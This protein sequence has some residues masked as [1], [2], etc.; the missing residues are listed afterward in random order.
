MIMEPN[1]LKSLLK[2]LEDALLKL[3]YG[4]KFSLLLN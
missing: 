4:V 1:S 2:K 3:L